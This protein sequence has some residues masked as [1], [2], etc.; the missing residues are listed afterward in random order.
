MNKCVMLAF[1][2][3]TISLIAF[4]AL[5]TDDMDRSLRY[6][7]ESNY[8]IA[9]K[10]YDNIMDK[11]GSALQD[12]PENEKESVCTKIRY[13][14]HDNRSQIVRANIWDK[15]RFKQYVKDLESYSE[16]IGCP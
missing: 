14:L 1:A 5:A 4:P 13:G 11:Y 16:T 15:K 8:R 12:M 3:V 6:Q 2:I 7:A 10:A 9:K